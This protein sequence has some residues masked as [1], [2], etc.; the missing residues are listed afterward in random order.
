M[1][2]TVC[3]PE[4]VDRAEHDHRREGSA[5]ARFS[6]SAEPGDMRSSA[7][8]VQE[9]RMAYHLPFVILNKLIVQSTIIAVKD[10]RSLVFSLG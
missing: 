8:R 5:V 2:L 10:L 4:Q 9:L 7:T 3:H 6:P 1:T